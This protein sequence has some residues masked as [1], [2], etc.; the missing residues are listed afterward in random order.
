[1]KKPVI[2]FL[3]FIIVVF[4][5]CNY[6]ST[7]IEPPKAVQGVLNLQK[8]DLAEYGSVYLSGEWEF[9]WDSFIKPADFV[10]GNNPPL[11]GF[12]TLPG[13]YSAES[14]KN[15]SLEQEGYSTYRLI[16]NNTGT[17]EQLAL[18]LSSMSTPY[19]LYVNG[20]EITD[21]GTVGKTEKSTIPEEVWPKTVDIPGGNTVEV[22]LHVSHFHY[23][24]VNSQNI[25]QLGLS[26]DLHKRR[27]RSLITQWIIFG[28]LLIMGLY[29]LSLFVVRSDDKAT[30]FFG[31]FCLLISIYNVTNGERYIVYMFPELGIDAWYRVMTLNA[32]ISVP[33]FG[34]F[35][36]NI[37]SRYFP[38]QIYY[39]IFAF[40]ALFSIITLFTH[41]SFYMTVMPI[42]HLFTLMACL[43]VI[44]VLVRESL[45]GDRIAYV[46]IAGF[47]VF[48]FTIANDLLYENNIIQSIRVIHVGLFFF[49]FSQSFVLALNYARNLRAV[50]KLTVD[51][52]QTNFLLEETNRALNYFVPHEFLDMLQKN[53]ITD[54]NLGDNVLKEMS[55]LFCDIRAFTTLSEKMN[56]QE[57]FAFLNSYLD[58]ITPAIQNHNGFIDKYM[59]DAVMA[60]F[61]GNPENALKSAI[62]MQTEIKKYNVHRKKTGY[63]TI[64]VGIGIHFGKMILGTIGYSKR[65]D[66]TVISDVVNLVSRLEG[67]TKIYGAG[68]IISEELLSLISDP[69]L[70]TYRLLD[71][72]V[73]VGKTQPISIIEIFDGL[74]D[75]EFSLKTMSKETFEEGIRLYQEKKFEEAV[76][77]FTDV[78]E[79]NPADKAAEYYIARC[80]NLIE[81]GI[82]EDWDGIERLYIK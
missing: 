71:R 28:A 40:A 47:L 39:F 15:K 45:G 74:L 23:T 60:L 49:I 62:E 19:R 42:Y 64:R 4:A 69:T 3:F 67:L 36:R 63:E 58:R 34:V 35:I 11:T 24:E 8:W 10:S 56:P 9:Y 80:R 82:P 55:V 32:I 21:N 46:L 1:M 52:K 43:F 2:F 59:G 20:M 7:T 48:F 5:S 41:H 6:N 51:L 33:V 65:M 16:I 27:D 31:L 13:V 77:N 81:E 68:I 50:E 12:F 38:K 75:R 18:R 76:I 14:F 79:K 26:E 72:V 70:Y 22:V 37:F 57:N 73:V 25:I 78:L 29:H 54:V 53:S 66:T 61:S 17:T 44:Y 30:L